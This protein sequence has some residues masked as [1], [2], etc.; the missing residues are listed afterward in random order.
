[1]MVVDDVP[2]EVKVQGGRT[3]FIVDRVID[4]VQD[5]A[6]TIMEYT[7]EL[8]QRGPGEAP[9]LNVML[10][11]N[12]YKRVDKLRGMDDADVGNIFRPTTRGSSMTGIRESGESGM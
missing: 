12:S 4:D 6:M 1:M 9:K 8:D 3:E 10:G 11:D 2:D 5:D 7:G